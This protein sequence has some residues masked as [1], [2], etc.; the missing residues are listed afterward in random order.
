MPLRLSLIC[1]LVLLCTLPR[2]ASHVLPPDSPLPATWFPTMPSIDDAC[3]TIQECLGLGHRWKKPNSRI[4][5]K[6]LFQ[7]LSILK[8]LLTI[9]ENRRPHYH[10]LL[11]TVSLH[12]I[13]WTLAMNSQLQPQMVICADSLLQW[14]CCKIVRF[15]SR[16]VSYLGTCC[17]Q[18]CLWCWS[19]KVAWGNEWSTHWWFP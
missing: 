5:N 3:N 15:M 17:L 9:L 19:S 6:D 11:N 14:M 12:S 4:L 7:E 2:L 16:W 10:L 13:R 1:I 18:S 8:T